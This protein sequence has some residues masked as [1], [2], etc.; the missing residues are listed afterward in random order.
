MEEE[1][2][3]RYSQVGGV[4][5]S[6]FSPPPVRAYCALAYEDPRSSSVQLHRLG[7]VRHHCW[8]QPTNRPYC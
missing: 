6:T 3:L 1:I 5:G 4:P 8:L 2:G 7:G